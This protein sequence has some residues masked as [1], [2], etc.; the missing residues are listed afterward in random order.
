MLVTLVAGGHRLMYWEF[1]AKPSNMCSI[2]GTIK[3]FI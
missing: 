3:A 1:A 2:L